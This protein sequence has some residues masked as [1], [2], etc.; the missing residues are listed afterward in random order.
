[1]HFAIG[2]GINGRGLE[3]IGMVRLARVRWAI[4]SSLSSPAQSTATV[5]G[6]MSTPGNGSVGVRLVCTLGVCTEGGG[7]GLMLVVLFHLGVVGAMG[8]GFFFDAL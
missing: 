7:G 3:V 6:T 5:G 8:L 4:V 1:M 2:S